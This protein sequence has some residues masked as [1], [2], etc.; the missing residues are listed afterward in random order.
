MHIFFLWSE[1]IIGKNDITA[2]DKALFAFRY[3]FPIT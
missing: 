1:G 2:L 3:I